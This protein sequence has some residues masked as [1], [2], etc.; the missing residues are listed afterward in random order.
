MTTPPARGPRYMTLAEE[1]HQFLFFCAAVKFR[2]SSE[3]SVLAPKSVARHP[4][5]ETAIASLGN[6]SFEELVRI[7]EIQLGRGVGEVGLKIFR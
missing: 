1:G 3:L 2:P 4:P 5:P 6:V 7:S